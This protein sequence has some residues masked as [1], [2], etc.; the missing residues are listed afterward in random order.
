MSVLMCA[1]SCGSVSES[2]INLWHEAKCVNVLTV[3]MNSYIGTVPF[4]CC[5]L[6]THAKKTRMWSSLVVVNNVPWF[7]SG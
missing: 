7:D 1:V 2:N 5:K 3:F 4:L 6:W